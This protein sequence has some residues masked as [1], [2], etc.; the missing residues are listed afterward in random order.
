MG[1]K[2]VT[3]FA[4]CMEFMLILPT[5]FLGV[6]PI[7]VGIVFEKHVRSALGLDCAE[8]L[9]ILVLALLA[10]RLALYGGGGFEMC[11]PPM[12]VLS[13]RNIC[14][15]DTEDEERRLYSSVFSSTAMRSHK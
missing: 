4:L 1:A 10:L 12:A 11:K 7:F 9:D 8:M 15:A 13:F 2:D 5:L 3:P 14:R 6:I